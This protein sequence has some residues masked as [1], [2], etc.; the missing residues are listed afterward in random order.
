MKNWIKRFLKIRLLQWVNKKLTKTKNQ[1]LDEKAH[2]AL[3]ELDR[4]RRSGRGR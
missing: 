4:I 3:D 1:G 2:D